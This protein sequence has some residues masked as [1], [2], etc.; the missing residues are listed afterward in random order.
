[1]NCYR[2]KVK[3]TNAMRDT[4]CNTGDDVVPGT[5]RECEDGEVYVVARSA[6]AAMKMFRDSIIESC[7]RIGVG[8]VAARAAAKGGEGE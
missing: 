3:T 5:Y 8:L 7:E 1:M 4:Y 6:V 2:V